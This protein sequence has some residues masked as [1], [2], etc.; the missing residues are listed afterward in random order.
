MGKYQDGEASFNFRPDSGKS[1]DSAGTARQDRFD[2]FNGSLHDHTWSATP[3][4][5]DGK[6]REGWVG[7]GGS[8]SNSSDSGSSGSG[9]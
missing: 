5:G 9:K 7:R 3:R 2:N 1:S 8:D 4:S 6:H